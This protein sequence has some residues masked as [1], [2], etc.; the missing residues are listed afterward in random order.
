MTDDALATKSRN[1][2]GWYE[3]AINLRGCRLGLDDIKTVY[4]D[5]QKINRSFG[6]RLIASIPRDASMT[7]VQWE[8]HQLFLLEDAFCLVVVIKGSRD[9]QLYGETASIFD[10]PDLPRPIKSVYFT[11]DIS[12]KRHSEGKEPI[13]H[14]SAFIDFSKPDLFDPNPL[15]SEPTPNESELKVNA[16][17]ITF[18]NA[19]QKAVEKR[20]MSRKTWYGSIHRSFS[21]DIG[22]WFFALPIGMYFSAYYMDKLI[23]S[24]SKFDLFRWPLFAYFLGLSL[25]SYRALVAYAKWAFPVNVL[26]ENNDKALRHRLALGGFSSW[27][28]Y[29]LA[30]TVY[31]TLVG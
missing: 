7:D 8:R 13:N 18:F 10:S 9:E 20:L 19:V 21:Y 3:E 15:V 31:A 12:F 29:Q 17:D 4:S 28:F 16:Q 23:P 24:G 27:L 2:V 5:I 1:Q 14:V 22:L 6:E 25:I 11:N 26:I 30:S